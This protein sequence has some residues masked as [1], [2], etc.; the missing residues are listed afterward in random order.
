MSGAPV[1]VF[2]DKPRRRWLLSDQSKWMLKG[3]GYAVAGIAVV[4]LMLFGWIVY[5]RS[6]HGQMAYEYIQNA[7]AQQQQ[8]QQPKATVQPT[9]PS[10]PA[11]PTP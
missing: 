8:A 11:K 2:D 9:P 3:A 7:I 6:L 4:A 5:V 10:L 1:S